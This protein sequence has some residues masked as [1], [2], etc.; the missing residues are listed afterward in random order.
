MD[1]IALQKITE[2][3]S[4]E[5]I[6]KTA[7]S[8]LKIIVGNYDEFFGKY[9]IHIWVKLPPK[10]FEIFLNCENE[11]GLKN[12]FDGVSLYIISKYKNILSI[13]VKVKSIQIMY[14]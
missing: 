1:K 3:F 7:I 14:L 6:P 12:R 10:D 11:M 5:I 9:N 8:D 2:K 4:M 13:D